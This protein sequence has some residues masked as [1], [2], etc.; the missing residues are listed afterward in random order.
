[1]LID[2]LDTDDIESM[3]SRNT[4]LAA[5]AGR[6]DLVQL[7]SMLALSVP[8]ALNPSLDPANDPWASHPFG[9]EMIK[10]L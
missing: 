10:S 6:H 1:M 8:P 9:R 4:D 3:C 2:R 5:K 7:W